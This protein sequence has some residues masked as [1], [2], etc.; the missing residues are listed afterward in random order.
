MWDLS[1]TTMYRHSSESY[2]RRLMASERKKTKQKNLQIPKAE[3]KKKSLYNFIK[4]LCFYISY[5]K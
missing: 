3:K 4:C 5:K 2:T 1:K